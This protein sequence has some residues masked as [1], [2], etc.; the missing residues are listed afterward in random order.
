M[1]SFYRPRDGAG[2]RDI[3]EQAIAG[4]MNADGLE[5]MEFG[6]YRLKTEPDGSELINF[7]GP[8][9]TYTHFSMGDVLDGSVPPTAFKDKIVLIGPTAV[10]IGDVRPTPFQSADYMGVEIHA[11]VIDNLLHNDEKGRGFLSRGITEE[12]IDLFFIVAFGIGMGLVFAR[13]KP[14]YSTGSMI[15]A[16]VLFGFI[17][18]FAFAHFGMWLYAVVPAGTLL[19]NYGTITSF[20]MVTEEREKR[21]IRKTFERYVSPGVIRLIEKDPKKYFQAGGES[22]ELSIMFSDIRS[23]TTCRRA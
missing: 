17:V 20:R 9:K 5:R 7:A 18:Y 10:G 3:K 2:S 23:F 15:L 11:N 8:Y 12:M 4:Y 14:L 16:L 21:K 22:K 13:L 19:V 6:Q 1:V